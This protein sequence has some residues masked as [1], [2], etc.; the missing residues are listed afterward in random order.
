MYSLFIKLE[1]VNEI[2]DLGEVFSVAWMS[3]SAKNKIA[4]IRI[5]HFLVTNFYRDSYL[6]NLHDIFDE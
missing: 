5:Q 4:K 6:F 2:K 1:I 3:E